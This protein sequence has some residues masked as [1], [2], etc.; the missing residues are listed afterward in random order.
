MEDYFG[1]HTINVKYFYL[2]LALKWYFKRNKYLFC[3]ILKKKEENRTLFS[4]Y[5]ACGK[6][7]F[8]ALYASIQKQVYEGTF[9]CHRGTQLGKGMLKRP[10]I[11]N[12]VSLT[13]PSEAEEKPCERKW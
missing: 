4:C 3:W 7:F 2:Y 6:I 9:P 8:L 13:L 1:P 11:F 5:G 10:C 12:T